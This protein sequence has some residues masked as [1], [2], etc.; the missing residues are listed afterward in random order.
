MDVPDKNNSN[1]PVLDIQYWIEF[2]D[3][4][5]DSSI[6]NN[7]SQEESKECNNIDFLPNE[8]KCLS[9]SKPFGETYHDDFEIDFDSQLKKAISNINYDIPKIEMEEFHNF[10][11]ILEE[12]LMNQDDDISIELKHDS[13]ILLHESKSNISLSHNK[14]LIDSQ[15]PIV[16]HLVNDFEV[17][18]VN[19]YKLDG[20]ASK[21]IT[22]NVLKRTAKSFG[23]NR[24]Q[25]KSILSD[26]SSVTSKV[27][28]WTVD[29]C[30]KTFK[31]DSSLRKHILTHG[32]KQYICK[33]KGCGKKFLDN[34]K[35]KR[36][37][38]VHTGRKPF[39]WK[40]CGKKFSLDFNL[41]THY[42][43]HT[44]EKPY[45]WE[46]PECGKR[47]TQSS[48][49]TAHLKTHCGKDQA[50]SSIT[51]DLRFYAGRYGSSSSKSSQ[52]NESESWESELS[53]HHLKIFNVWKIQKQNLLLMRNKVPK[54]FWIH[55]YKH[56][57]ARK[58]SNAQDSSEEYSDTP[59][60]SVIGNV[61]KIERFPNNR[62]RNNVRQSTNSKIQNR[63][64]N[65]YQEKVSF[66]IEKM[67]KPDMKSFPLKRYPAKKGVDL[68]SASTKRSS[69]ESS[70][71]KDSCIEKLLN[72]QIPSVNLVKV[73]HEDIDM[74]DEQKSE[75]S[76]DKDL[77]LMDQI[78]NEDLKNEIQAF[79]YHQQ[80]LDDGELPKQ[81]LNQLNVQMQFECFSSY[82]DQEFDDAYSQAMRLSA[83]VLRDTDRTPLRARIVS[84]CNELSVIGGGESNCFLLGGERETLN[85]EPFAT[86]K[87]FSANSAFDN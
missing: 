46:F 81:D 33:F 57:D 82:Q 83:R 37:Q 21:Q 32:E 5:E 13:D 51:E 87:L 62:R 17:D 29:P 54:V 49:L 28:T 43:T 34:S 55:K 19:S 84:G 24:S 73:E 70:K 60:R 25:E 27:H 4:E 16:G 61:Y 2:D 30:D 67:I 80:L 68:D 35:L 20:P 14:N 56:V 42:R 48:N 11:N 85:F 8:P 6:S 79:G 9:E 1:E 41:R 52:D 86:G 58:T 78:Q 72:I 47:F 74:E 23:R 18:L 71:Q 75:V 7:D 77:E 50:S 39:K 76:E 63:I 26:C 40:I 12:N 45:I 38:L 53:C 15:L 64:C 31:D 22:S 66:K 65:E 36:H 3:S 69:R 44:G 10:N 59:I